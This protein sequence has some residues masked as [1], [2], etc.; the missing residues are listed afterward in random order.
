VKRSA[1]LVVIAL[2]FAAC[3]DDD[4]SSQADAEDDS[5]ATTT[6]LVATATIPDTGPTDCLDI[7][8]E[9]DVQAVAGDTYVFREANPDRS[10]C[11]F[12][13]GPAGII[14]SWRTSDEFGYQQSRTQSEA[15]GD[16]VESVDVCDAAYVL[17]LQGAIL[18]LET[19]AADQA[20][21]YNA[22]LTGMG[23]D[24]ARAWAESLV[25]NTC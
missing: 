15:T 17:E 5:D 13:S 23:M 1:I 11:T 12:T 6:T 18:V 19:Y 16:P 20:R 9:A 3:G 10:A 7:W 22:T 21:A 2:V 25:A 14:L 8:P 4:L 24:E